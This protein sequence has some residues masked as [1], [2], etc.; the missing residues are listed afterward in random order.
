MTE[1]KEQPEKSQ[2]GI[3]MGYVP[4][5]QNSD[6]VWKQIELPKELRQ[7]ISRN[8]PIARC[9]HSLHI[10]AGCYGYEIAQAVIW[11]YM[12]RPEMIYKVRIVP[13]RIEYDIKSYR[14]EDNISE[15]GEFDLFTEKKE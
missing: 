9:N 11:L 13:Y 15:I 5:Y 1:K 2:K 8:L 4:E 10:I 7:C 3:E 6:G 12:A 14:Q